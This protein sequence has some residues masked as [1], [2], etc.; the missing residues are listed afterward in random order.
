MLHSGIISIH[1]YLFVIK[2]PFLCEKVMLVNNI[3]C[4]N[5]VLCHFQQSLCHFFGEVKFWNVSR[6]WNS[7]FE[8]LTWIA[9][10]DKGIVNICIC[11]VP[12][13]RTMK[14]K[15][16]YKHSLKISIRKSRK[17]WSFYCLLVLHS[18][19]WSVFS[20][21]AI[22]VGVQC[23]VHLLSLVIYPFW[24]WKTLRLLLI[25]CYDNQCHIEHSCTSYCF[26]LLFFILINF[27]PRKVAWYK[28]Y[29]YSLLLCLIIVN[30]LLYWLN[31]FFGQI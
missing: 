15:R 22:L 16:K 19:K 8:P 18:T 29:L 9:L 30:I 14:S 23:K 27:K 10:S 4:L 2:C 31:L 11:K 7:E 5:N 12:K 1:L 17:N 20:I 26:L 25:F 28:E 13:A 24:C 21:L 3:L 6:S